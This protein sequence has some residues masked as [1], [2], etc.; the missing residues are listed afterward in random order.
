MRKK[1]SDQLR[2]LIKK[3]FNT[4][5]TRV[6]LFGSSV[7]GKKKFYD[8]DVGFL[9]KIDSKKLN[10]LC[11]EL[12]ESTLPYEVDLVDFNQVKASFKEYVFSQPVKWIK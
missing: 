7:Y 2:E 4:R 11:E 9:G 10:Q 1:Y 8:I 3:H 6:F 5:Q 12:E